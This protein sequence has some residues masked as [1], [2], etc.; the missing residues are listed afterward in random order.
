MKPE[1]FKLLHDLHR[2]REDSIKRRIGVAEARRRD[3][4]AR[5]DELAAS[6]DTAARGVQENIALRETFVR[7]WHRIGDEMGDMSR[8]IANCDQEI[9]GLRRELVEAHR[10]TA[11]FGKLRDRDRVAVA[12]RDELRQARMLDDLGLRFGNRVGA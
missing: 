3:L 9:D 10:Q 11:A 4:V 8:H 5:R 7:Y 2:E 6:R 12:K 1:R